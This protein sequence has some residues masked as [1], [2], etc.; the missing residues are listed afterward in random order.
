MLLK[1]ARRERPGETDIHHGGISSLHHVNHY[2]NWAKLRRRG[3]RI[4]VAMVLCFAGKP[5]L[6]WWP[7]NITI[8]TKHLGIGMAGP[9]MNLKAGGLG[10]VAGQRY[11]A[12]WV[13]L[14][15][16]LLTSWRR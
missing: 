4:A 11:W 5:A 7:L 15:M 2:A 14:K 13:Q 16:A 1:A 3:P 6:V 8:A 10:K 9:P 12:Q